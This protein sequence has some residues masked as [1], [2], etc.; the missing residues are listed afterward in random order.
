MGP[1]FL[2]SAEPFQALAQRVVGVRRGGIELEDALERRP[3]WLG[4][5]GVEV[6]APERLEDR[7]FA[8]LQ[9]VRAFEHDRRLGVMARREQGL[10]ALEQLVGRF[11]LAGLVG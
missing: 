3:R 7:R 1:G 11:V 2:A 4:L 5:T 10:T 6:G 9:P 8:R